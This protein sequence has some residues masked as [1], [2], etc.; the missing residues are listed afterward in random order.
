MY[1]GEV[2]DTSI[3]TN[4]I[5]G[6][7]IHQFRAILDHLIYG[8]CEIQAP[9]GTDLSQV[10]F[11]ISKS[12]ADYLADKRVKTLQ[13]LVKQS[14]LT[15]IEACQPFRRHPNAPAGSPLF[16]L[17]KLDILDKHC[18]VLKLSHT[19]DLSPGLTFKQTVLPG[20][21]MFEVAFPDSIDPDQLSLQEFAPRVVFDESVGGSETLVEV[22]DGVKEEVVEVVNRLSQFF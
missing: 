15:E 7:A 13:G 18:S 17:H 21:L 1:V 19:L 9:T 3:E 5:I 11:P 20:R 6:D 12:H 22:M 8:V 4:V 2:P 14:V 10:Y 16:I